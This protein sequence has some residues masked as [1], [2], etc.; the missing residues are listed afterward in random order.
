MTFNFHHMTE[1]FIAPTHFSSFGEPVVLF[2]T[3]SSD[4]IPV[5]GIVE[6]THQEGNRA[7]TQ[8]VIV[9]ANVLVPAKVDGAD[10]VISSTWHVVLRGQKFS[11]E[12]LGPVSAGFRKLGLVVLN[13]ETTKAVSG[14]L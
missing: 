12:S 10:L 3:P 14:R 11:I 13:K 1:Q 8:G 4:E 7:K 5:S 2:N 9:R 6:V